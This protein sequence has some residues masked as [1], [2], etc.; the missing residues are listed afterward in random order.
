MQVLRSQY[1]LTVPHEPL[2][3][4]GRGQRGQEDTSERTTADEPRTIVT[5]NISDNWGRCS[6]HARLIADRHCM[7]FVVTRPLFPA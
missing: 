6:E 4:S 7:P 3:E 2:G 5:N 1:S